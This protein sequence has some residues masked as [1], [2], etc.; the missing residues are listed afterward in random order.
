MDPD[1][2]AQAVADAPL[3]DGVVDAA[4][5]LR[6]L[7]EQAVEPLAANPELRNRLLEI[8]RAHDLVIDETSQDILIDAYGVVD[9]ERAREVVTSW[10]AYLEENKDEIA[11]LQLLYSQGDKAKVTFA[12]LRELAERIKRPPHNWTPD[13]LWNAY[14]AIEIDPANP[15]IRRTDR[16]TVTDLISLVRFT[17]KQEENLVPYREAVQARYAGWLAAQHQAGASFTETQRWWLDRIA[18]VVAQAND[19][20]VD[21]LEKAPFTERGGVDGAVRDLG[22]QASAWLEQLNQELT[23]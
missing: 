13:L 15:H 14:A 23:A 19:V 10:K 6:Q 18:D 2:Q 7:L 3:V 21:D 8:R 16:H 1:R 11:A 5:A 17:L 4:A 12:E 22:A 20:G 9:T